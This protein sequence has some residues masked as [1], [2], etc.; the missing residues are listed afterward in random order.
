LAKTIRSSHAPLRLH[1]QLALH[2][3]HEILSVHPTIPLL[4]EEDLLVSPPEED[5]IEEVLVRACAFARAVEEVHVPAEGAEGEEDERV[6][7]P[8]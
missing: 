2:D 8:E 6:L 1:A 5:L 7:E 3:L 4:E